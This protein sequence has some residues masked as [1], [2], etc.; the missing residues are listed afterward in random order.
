MDMLRF[1]K[2]TIGHSWVSDYGNPD[3]KEHFENNYQYSPL[4]NVK[5]PV[6]GKFIKAIKSD[7]L[8]L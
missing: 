1:H 5:T 2:F 3:E 6:D 4:H 8:Y 7:Y